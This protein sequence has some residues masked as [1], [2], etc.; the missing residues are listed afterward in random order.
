M[1][2]E[3]NPERASLYSF[4]TLCGTSHEG[5]KHAIMVDSNVYPPMPKDQ[6]IRKEPVESPRPR[7]LWNWLLTLIAGIFLAVCAFVFIPGLAFLASVGVL[8][9]WEAVEA[10]ARDLVTMTCADPAII[11]CWT[12]G[13]AVLAALLVI[14]GVAVGGWAAVDLSKDTFRD[15]KVLPGQLPKEKT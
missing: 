4:C 15:L 12:Q 9:L 1:T 11:W 7:G 10:L 14:F 6:D 2:Q 13:Q 3:A 8:G 5:G